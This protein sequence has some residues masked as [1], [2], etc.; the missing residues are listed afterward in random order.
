MIN[1]NITVQLKTAAGMSETAVTGENFGAGQLVRGNGLL[2]V[3]VK[4]K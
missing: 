4:E 1:S 2:L 3:T